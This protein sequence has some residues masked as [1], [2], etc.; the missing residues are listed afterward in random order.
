[1]PFRVSQVF[2]LSLSCTILFSTHAYSGNLFFFSKPALKKTHNAMTEMILYPGSDAD[3]S[4]CKN[5]DDLVKEKT[6]HLWDE[7]RDNKDLSA[8]LTIFSNLDLLRSGLLLKY[9]KHISPSGPTDSEMSGKKSRKKIKTFLDSISRRPLIL[10]FAD[11]SKENQFKLIDL[12]IQSDHNF[13]RR[14][15]FS[16]KTFYTVKSYEGKISEC[17]SGVL[18]R[19][20]ETAD[21]LPQTP[22]FRTH[23]TLN[24][25][26]NE[27]IGELDY[28]VVGSGAAASVVGAGLQDSGK[29]VLMLE[30]GPFYMPGAINATDNF[31]F[32]NGGGLV[33]SVDG[34]MFFM[35]GEVTGGGI[36]VNID[37]SYPPTLPYIAKQFDAWH[38][39]GF[40]SEGLWSKEQLAH[41]WNWVKDTFSPRMTGPADLNEN[42]RI[43]K[44]GAESLGYSW[45]WYELNTYEPGRS[46]HQVTHK[47]SSTEK[48]LIPA[49]N[50]RVNPLTLLAN[51]EVTKVQID[52]GIARGV[53]FKVTSSIDRPGIIEDLYQLGLKPGQEVFVRAKKV[54]LSAGNL[55]STKILLQSKIENPAIGRG[56]VSHPFVMVMGKFPYPVNA[57]LGTPSSIFVD[58]FLSISPEDQKPGFLIESAAGNPA[59][60]AVLIPGSPLDVYQHMS[61]LK[62][63]AGLGVILVEDVNPDNKITLDKKG[64]TQIHYQLSESDRSRLARGVR[65][66]AEILLA[67]GA[68]EVS[69]NTY[70]SILRS[71]DNSKM[72]LISSSDQLRNIEDNYKLTPNKNLL[73]GAHMM[74]ANKIGTHPWNSVVNEQHEVWDVSN[75]Y[76]VDASVFPESV[77]ANPMQTIYTMAR[78]FVENHLQEAGRPLKEQDL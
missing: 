22:Q 69:F 57:H 60:A 1:M 41:G 61:N 18:E 52:N 68:T 53:W 38:Q 25:H 59:A 77:G 39:R 65:K 12:L 26:G 28:I 55:G 45:A 73:M 78:L 31:K 72:K 75:L 29:K 62:N 23:L 37:M 2:S 44:D 24:K 17:L 15:G 47:K 8:A 4:V 63:I 33:S 58:H 46:P 21:P 71:D 19:G 56:F 67:A 36:S 66:G 51:A 50:R 10:S 5:Y 16:L 34:G 20:D 76:V 48:L 13:Y 6:A 43:L 11:L 42:N 35:N 27:L 30:K 64:R 40:I 9:Y 70:E 7:V 32:M 74:G 54:I 14:I 49:M 3:T